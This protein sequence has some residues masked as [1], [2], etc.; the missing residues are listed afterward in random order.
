MIRLVAEA[1]DLPK[2]DGEGTWRATVEIVAFVGLPRLSARDGV[3]AVCLYYGD[4]YERTL[5]ELYSVR[6][7]E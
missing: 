3:V 6:A 7:L 2:P 5:E 1:P 4:L